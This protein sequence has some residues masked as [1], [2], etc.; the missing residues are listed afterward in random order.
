MAVARVFTYAAD[1]Q[2]V[3]AG[4]RGSTALAGAVAAGEAGPRRGQRVVAGAVD[5]L[6]LCEDEEYCWDEDEE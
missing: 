3:G 1:A 4:T 6:D 5:G 2:T